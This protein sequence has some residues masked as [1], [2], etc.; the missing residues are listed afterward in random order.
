MADFGES[1]ER[2]LNRVAEAAVQEQ[3]ELNY[4]VQVYQ[5]AKGLRAIVTMTA[6]SKPEACPQEESDHAEIR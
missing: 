4:R 6:G 5:G 2:V 1:L 3:I